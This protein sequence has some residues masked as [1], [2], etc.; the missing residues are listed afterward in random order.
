VA[1]QLEGRLLEV[2]DCNILCP[3]WVGED[4]DPGTCD[5]VEGYHIDSGTVNGVDVSGLTVAVLSHIPGN[6]LAGNHRVVL[7]V[8]DK[9]SEEQSEALTA[10]WTGKLGGPVAELSELWGELVAVRRAAISFTVREG[11]GTLKIGTWVEAEMAPYQ[12][13]N[14]DPTTLHNTPFSTIPGSPA[15]V[16]KASRYRRRTEELG[17]NDV[18]VEGRNAIQGSFRFQG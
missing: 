7:A 4:P 15:Y 9:A 5:S 8:D 10:V 12:G 16:A 2:C 1:Y 18:S 11:N 17:L 3:C 6:I 13:P 14:G